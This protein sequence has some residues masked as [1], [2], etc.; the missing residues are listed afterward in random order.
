[1]ALFS[2]NLVETKVQQRN[3]RA[4]ISV[5]WLM[6][7][8]T[9][10]LVDVS[11]TLAI[12]QSLNVMEISAIHPALGADVQRA[13]ESLAALVS[14]VGSLAS[15]P[16]LLLPSLNGIAYTQS[17]AALYRSIAEN[18]IVRHDCPHSFSMSEQEYSFLSL[19]CR[20]RRRWRRLRSPFSATMP[21][22]S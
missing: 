9:L 19:L 1:M 14:H 17:A 13:K 11:V 10:Q 8:V 5:R 6:A 7:D 20:I 18:A 4:H 15:R 2:R 12:V 21:W 22:R 3:A 16:L